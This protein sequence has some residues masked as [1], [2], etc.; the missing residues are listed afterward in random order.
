VSWRGV[1]VLARGNLAC[2][3]DRPLRYLAFGQR[4]RLRDLLDRVPV[5]IARREI[6][7]AV[8]PV[9]IFPQLLLDEAHRFDELAPVRRSQ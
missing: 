5:A 2:E 1:T 8:E 6:H 3:L 4:A 9:R 7:P